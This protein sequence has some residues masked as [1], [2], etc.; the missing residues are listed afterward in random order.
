VFLRALIPIVILASGF[1]AWKWLGKPIEP[2]K[3]RQ[4]MPQRLKTE[5]SVLN[6]TSYD[7]VIDSQGAVR[8]P[9][10][11][12]VKARMVGSGQAVGAT[13]HL[14]EI[15]RQ[16]HRRDP[17]ALSPSPLPFVKLPEEDGDAAVEAVVTDAHDKAPDPPPA[18]IAAGP[19]NEPVPG[20]S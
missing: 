16:R 2:P 4:H 8:A 11:G 15:F 20:D 19:A 14:G 9:F 10:D 3:P 6:P 18:Q 12:R 1:V 13:T 7:I 5:K 17:P